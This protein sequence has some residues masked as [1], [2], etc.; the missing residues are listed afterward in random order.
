MSK[1][2]TITTLL[3][4]AAV[5]ATLLIGAPI[6]SADPDGPSWGSEVKGCVK[7]SSCYG[8]GTRGEYVRAQARDNETPGYGN[9]IHR[10]ANPGASDPSGAV[11]G[12]NPSGDRPSGN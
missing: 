6:A 4:G 12:T 7:N 8:G 5:G 9:E 2:M 11:T 3:G 10:L 1:K